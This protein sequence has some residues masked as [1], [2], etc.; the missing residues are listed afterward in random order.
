MMVRPEITVSVQ[1]ARTLAIKVLQDHGAPSRG[2][3]LQADLLIEGDLRGH[4]SHGLLRLPRLVR[5]IAAGVLDPVTEGRSTWTHS[6]LLEVDGEHGFGAVIAHNALAEITER[7][8]STGVAAAVIKNN[9]HIGMLAHYAEK[10]A[11]GGQVLI[12][13]TTSEALVHPWGG[14]RA[15]VGTNP[16]AVGVP[17]AGDPV[18]FDMATG[19]VSMGKIHAYAAAGRPLEAGWAVDADGRP[20]LEAERAKDGAI[21]P[22]GGAKGYGLGI[23]LEA[24]VAALTQTA[25][26]RDVRGTLD[27]DHFSTKGDVFI[28]AQVQR[29]APH[30]VAAYLDD[31]RNSPSADPRTPVS[32]P[33]DRS[34][35]RRR[36]ALIDGLSIPD[37]LWAELH[38]LASAPASK[39]SLK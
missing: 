30:A 12:A 38:T 36:R 1:E 4:P 34:A 33:G 31:V 15:M 26:G 20:T 17:S 10:V 21:A 5:R 32:V 16:I 14:R 11:S 8:A 29:G 7:A 18:V 22:F 24:L 2:A 9:N 25:L 23:A 19:A 39:G 3:Q 28:V 6:A 13:S 37:A 35:A 27:D